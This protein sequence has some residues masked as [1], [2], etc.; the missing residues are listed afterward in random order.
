ML[1]TEGN[2]KPAT[3]SMAPHGAERERCSLELIKDLGVH[4]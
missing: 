3:P 1:V 2:Q 4:G